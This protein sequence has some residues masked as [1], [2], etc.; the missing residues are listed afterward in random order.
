MGAWICLLLTISV[1]AEMSPPP[2][3]FTGPQQRGSPQS[4]LAPQDPGGPPT[5]ALGPP[6]VP[7]G[8]QPHPLLAP[9]GS[10]LEGSGADGMNPSCN[11]TGMGG[12]YR[13]HGQQPLRT[14]HYTKHR[15][16]APVGLLA[17]RPAPTRPHSPRGIASPEGSE[18]CGGSSKVTQHNEQNLRAYGT[19]TSPRSLQATPLAGIP[20]PRFP[21]YWPR[22]GWSRKSFWERK[23]RKTTPPIPDPDG[24]RRARGAERK[25]APPGPRRG[26]TPAATLRRGVPGVI[27]DSP[28]KPSGCS[29]S[30]RTPGAPSPTAQHPSVPG[31]HRLR[32]QPGRPRAR[33]LTRRRF[34]V[35]ARARGDSG[36]QDAVLPA[37]LGASRRPAAAAPPAPSRR[38]SNTCPAPA[39]RQ[40]RGRSRPSALGAGPA[41]QRDPRLTTR[42]ARAR[43]G[44]EVCGGR[45]RPR[46]PGDTRRAP[47]PTGAP[48]LSRAGIGCEGQRAGASPRSGTGSRAGGS[49]FAPGLRMKAFLVGKRKGRRRRAA[50]TKAGEAGGVRPEPRF[51]P[52]PRGD[53]TRAEGPCGEDT[54]PPTPPPEGTSVGPLGKAGPGPPT[55]AQR[56]EGQRGRG[57]PEPLLRPRHPA[58]GPP[59]PL[60]R[61]ELGRCR[62]P[63]PSTRLSGAPSSLLAPGLQTR[64]PESSLGFHPGSDTPKSSVLGESLAGLPGAPHLCS[65]RAEEPPKAPALHPLSV[66][67]SL[68]PQPA[69]HI[70]H[71]TAARQRWRWAPTSQA[72]ARSAEN[73]DSGFTG[74]KRG[75]VWHL[76]S[77]LGARG[78]KGGRADPRRDPLVRSA[79]PSQ[80][81]RGASAHAA[82]ACAVILPVRVA[83]HPWLSPPPP[84]TAGSGGST[85]PQRLRGSQA[86]GVLALPLYAVTLASNASTAS[87]HKP[88]L[89]KS[90][91]TAQEGA[92]TPPP[93]RPPSCP[94]PELKPLLRAW[95]GGG[96]QKGPGELAGADAGTGTCSPRASPRAVARVPPFASLR[97]AGLESCPGDTPHPQLSGTWAAG[98]GPHHLP[99]N[100]S[101]GHF[102]PEGSHS[103]RG[104]ATRRHLAGQLWRLSGGGGFLQEQTRARDAGPEKSGVWQRPRRGKEL[105]LSKEALPREFR[106][107]PCDRVKSSLRPV[108]RA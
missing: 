21:T 104:H 13:S 97:Q 57:T 23:G 33:A 6:A 53:R 85:P 77:W 56:P 89:A 87:P 20:G 51:F 34:G 28:P 4:T 1:P 12:P 37:P 75:S 64:N 91:L 29:R 86:P 9:V 105:G 84:Q 36:G 90:T 42:P 26:P 108:F 32:P 38:S 31:G 107:P 61:V 99:G 15:T 16:R 92:P 18:R 54:G 58:P 46:A 52:R 69:S 72:R 63:R 101:D 79:D 96:C 44:G 22:A 67:S 47:P 7:S 81:S 94:R 17:H 59:H 60:S 98:Q 74:C 5:T 93:Q 62:R 48:S 25:R 41:S 49:R 71:R 73:A 78:R 65:G 50:E 83:G 8:G 11:L 68:R 66:P 19:P 27:P 43:G 80:A 30:A 2:Q 39:A 95:Q 76:H 40:S 3:A 102:T 106:K 100:P 88:R 45:G 35:A 55:P 14:Q 24:H 103:P 82:P 10:F 70:G